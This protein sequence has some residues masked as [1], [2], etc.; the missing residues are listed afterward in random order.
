MRGKLADRP[1]YRTLLLQPSPVTYRRKGNLVTS[2]TE[3]HFVWVKEPP[4][5]QSQLL[6]MP[7]SDMIQ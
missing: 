3:P 5:T 4:P 2:N 6:R 7:C 1:G